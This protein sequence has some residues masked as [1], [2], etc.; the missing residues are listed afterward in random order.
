MQVF[1]ISNASDDKLKFSA[2][3]KFKWFPEQVSAPPFDHIWA[4]LARVLHPDGK[5]K[6]RHLNTALTLFVQLNTH[7][8]K[9]LIRYKR[10]IRYGQLYTFV[11]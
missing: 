6:L 1:I 3:E 2:S 11:N 4:L 8:D 5:F 9:Q 7:N 10:G